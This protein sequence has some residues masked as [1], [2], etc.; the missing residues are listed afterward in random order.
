[1]RTLLIVF[2]KEVIDNFRD[3]RTL[4]SA[5][6]MGPLL[7]PM[8]FAFVINLSIERSLSDMDRSMKLPVIGAAHAPNLMRFLQSRNLE[9][10]D[11]PA[12]REAAIAAVKAG[13][14]DVVVIVPA[15]FGAQLGAGE[16]AR[17]ELVSDQSDQEAER[18]A[19]RARNAIAAYNQQLAAL[20]L[21]SR[22]VSPTVLQAINVDDVDVSTPSGRSGILL[23]MMSYFFIFALLMGGMYLAIDTTA[24]E[25]ERGSLEP[26]LSLPVTREQ[27]MLGKVAATC[28]FMAVSLM[29][30]LW[31]FFFAL[32]FMPLEQ[33]GMT[34]NFGPG[35]VL[36]AFFLLAP[37]ILL[38]A[39]LMTLV[40]SFTRSYKEAQ[41]W[42]S[43]VLIAPTLPILVVSILNVRPRLEFMFV[44]S[45]S[46]HLVLQ[47]LIKNEPLQW[48]HVAISVT[49]TLLLGSALT[50]ICAK[51]YRREGLLG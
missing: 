31:S 11:A 36:A 35:V 28:M 7:G 45:L 1:M 30:S 51:L 18:D 39:A 15:G 41:T 10:V 2:V 27:L 38:G 22:G 26:L 34:P 25:R 32:R 12:D 24:G 48:L 19:R 5:L 20:R 4:V 13:D 17:V 33:L 43:V 29:L 40:A 6:L 49:S 9:I 8:L 47:D 44:P 37:F 14:I 16:P 50:W 42:L 23:G 3:R 46:Q 21:I